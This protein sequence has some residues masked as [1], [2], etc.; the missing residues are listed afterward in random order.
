MERV[1]GIEPSW[2]AW[3]AGTLPLSYTRKPRLL[4]SPAYRGSSLFAFS[5]PWGKASLALSKALENAFMATKSGTAALLYLA[6]L[7]A[8]HGLAKNQSRAKGS[9]LQNFISCSATF[10]RPVALGCVPS[11]TPKSLRV[12]VRPS[13][14]GFMPSAQR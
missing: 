3:K 5:Q 10:C 13:L 6:A 2:P 11:R 7:D 1:N 9:V 12:Q 14:R 8:D 4:N